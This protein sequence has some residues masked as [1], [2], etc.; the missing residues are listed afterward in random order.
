M[1][2]SDKKLLSDIKT[3]GWHILKITPDEESPG[4]AFSVGLFHS[5]SHPEIVMFG[6][7]LDTLH[8]FI[9]LGSR[10]AKLPI[11]D[12]AAAAST[13]PGTSSLTYS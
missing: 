11:T 2:A 6:L 5:Y 7:N 8:E 12:A 13:T 4:F 10:V 9:N 3:Y 1:D